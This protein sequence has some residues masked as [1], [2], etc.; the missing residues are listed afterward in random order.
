VAPAFDIAGKQLADEQS[1]RSA[2]YLAVDAYRNRKIYKE[3]SSN[4]LPFSK[5]EKGRKEQ[6]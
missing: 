3:I 5:D 1:M 6:D 2:I 4:P